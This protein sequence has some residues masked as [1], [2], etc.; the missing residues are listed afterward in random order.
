MGEILN[1]H[2]ALLAEGA[3]HQTDRRA[4]RH[5]LCHR[6]P[7]VDR[8]V[9]GMGMDQHEPPG[10]LDVTEVTA[11]PY[12]AW[13]ARLVDDQGDLSAAGQDQR[14]TRGSAK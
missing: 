10:G 2:L 12:V 8:L 7:V 5:I 4:F 13:H 9:I 3:G 6:R 1:E 14:I 11:P